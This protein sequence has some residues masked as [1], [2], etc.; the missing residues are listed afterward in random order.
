SSSRF[1]RRERPRHT[2]VP[3]PSQMPSRTPRHPLCAAETAPPTTRP[4][5]VRVSSA[6]SFQVILLLPIALARHV[7]RAERMS[8]FKTLEPGGT[9]FPL[10]DDL[11]I[12]AQPD[13]STV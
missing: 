12:S 1:G 11:E 8:G 2:L 7:D 13:G 9:V 5:Q 3:F 4:N 10:V 6:G